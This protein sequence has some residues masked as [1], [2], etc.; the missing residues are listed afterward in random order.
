[1][2][3]FGSERLH[4]EIRSKRVSQSSSISSVPTTTSIRNDLILFSES[5]NIY[6]VLSHSIA[7][8]KKAKVRQ[9]KVLIT[10]IAQDV[11]MINKKK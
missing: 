11:K 8:I 2:V 9:V 7:L 6:V 1:M 3:K 4:A 10:K 5:N